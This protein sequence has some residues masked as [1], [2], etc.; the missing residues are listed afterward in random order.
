MFKNAKLSFVIT[1]VV[2]AASAIAMGM[3]FIM[4][5]VNV[6]GILI[7]DAESNMRTAIDANAQVIE[8]YLSGAERTT[9]AQRYTRIP[10]KK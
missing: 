9:G 2:A 4:S 5:S 1:I 3:V 6:N 8:E 7:N 10:M